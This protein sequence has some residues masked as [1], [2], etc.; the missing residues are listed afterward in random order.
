MNVVFDCMVLFQAAVRY[1]GPAAECLRRVEARGI[2]LLVSPATLDELRD[3][4]TRPKLARKFPILSD[5]HVTEFDTKIR[6]VATELTDVPT[7]FALP[8]DPD[9]EP[10]VNLAIAGNAK[11]LVSRDRDLLDLMQDPTFTT[12][13]PDLTI[14]DPGQFLTILD[15]LESTS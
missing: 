13:H 2:N 1:G 9:D 11:Y 6:A 14:C 7:V 3:V 8:R 4:M 15:A 5:E 12:A 10:Y